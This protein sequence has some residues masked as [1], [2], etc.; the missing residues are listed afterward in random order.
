[1]RYFISWSYMTHEY[2]NNYHENIVSQFKHFYV[3]SVIFGVAFG[4]L[5][6]IF[7]VIIREYFPN[8]NSKIPKDKKDDLISYLAC[9]V[10]HTL[11]V[12]A[13]VYYVYIDSFRSPQESAE[14][15]YAKEYAWIV[16]FIFGYFIA[17]TVLYAIPKALST[18][19]EYLFHHILGLGLI[20]SVTRLDGLILKHIPHV[21]LCEISSYCFAVAYILRMNGS[22]GTGVVKFLE[23]AFA[24]S[25]FL[26]RNVHLTIILWTLRH[27]FATHI[28]AVVI[29]VLVLILQFYWLY[30]I[31][32]ALIKKSKAGKAENHKN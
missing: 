7:P 29:F 16:P 10:H 24:L 14:M 12:P 32:I 13:G 15:N 5:Y 25:F 21:F 6:V 18:S 11:V 8:F 1:M 28:V 23:Y 22:K 20:L 17:D 26:T 31:V 2:V 19:A 3:Y 27:E 9:L 4:S 30:K